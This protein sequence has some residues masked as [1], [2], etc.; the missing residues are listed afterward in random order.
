MSNGKNR[1][2]LGPD[3]VERGSTKRSMAPAFQIPMV[4]RAMVTNPQTN[5]LE[6]T[7]ES[8]ALL[9]KH[10]E[11]A[12]KPE[13]YMDE[14]MT[15]QEANVAAMKNLEWFYSESDSILNQQGRFQD[16]AFIEA[17]KQAV[18]ENY[19]KEIPMQ[20][21]ADFLDFQ[22]SVKEKNERPF[23]EMDLVKLVKGKLQEDPNDPFDKKRMDFM[24]KEMEAREGGYIG[25]KKSEFDEMMEGM[26]DIFGGER[27]SGSARDRLNQLK[28]Q[29]GNQSFSDKFANKKKNF[30]H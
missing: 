16:P 10:M 9:L 21:K 14:G 15:A 26:D 22:M 8:K 13:D 4:R 3:A 23:G 5:M 30:N 12:K 18:N 19:V 2:G 20:S 28:Q 29:R 24:T 17:M 25:H 1:Q 27:P 7:E 6:H 11:T